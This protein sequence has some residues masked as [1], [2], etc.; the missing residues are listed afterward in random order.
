[1]NLGISYY[2]SHFPEDIERNL[3]EI[4]KAGCN[5]IVFAASEF[6]MG[7]YYPSS[8][9]LVEIVH[10]KGL[11]VFLDLWAH[12]R[13]FGGEGASFFLMY[14]Q[15]V[16]QISNKNKIIPRACFNN[17]KFRKFIEASIKK[18]MALGIDGFFWDEPHFQVFQ[19][20][21]E[22]TCFCNSCKKK[23]KKQY[24]KD[25]PNT[26]TE[27]F[28]E[29][30]ENSILEFLKEYSELIKKTNKNVLISICVFP[31]N[32]DESVS[33]NKICSIKEIDIFGSNPYWLRR[34]KN[35]NYVRNV[36]KQVVS[37]TKKYKK[38]SE[39]WIQL[40]KI[41]KGKEEEISKAIKLVYKEHPDYISAWTFRAGAE[42]TLQ[43][44]DWKKCWSKLNESYKKIRKTEQK[45]FK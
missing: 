28:K 31:Q 19:N 6:E 27:E 38:M 42:S 35:V 17:E 22:F 7:F 20:K 14:N 40:Y 43:C 5:Y 11:K 26:L 12:G 44:D 39:I 18:G 24:N 15:D 41:P 3:E 1:M 33:W 29:F 34:E 4:K 36:T 23:F 9:K 2:G 10:K 25:I 21:E 16:S 37:I 30:K 32:K 45:P 13:A 8:K